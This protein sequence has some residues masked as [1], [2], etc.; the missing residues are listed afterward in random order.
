MSTAIKNALLRAASNE[1]SNQPVVKRLLQELIDNIAGIGPGGGGTA[2]LS[3]CLFVDPAAPG[4]G[5]RSIASLELPN[6][7]PGTL[8]GIQAALNAALPGDAVVLSP[9]T[10]DFGSGGL[11]WPDPAGKGPVSLLGLDAKATIL[12]NDGTVPVILFD[13]PTVDAVLEELSF[14]TFDAPVTPGTPILSIVGRVDGGAV[15]I[16]RCE[17]FPFKTAIVASNTVPASAVNVV[18]SLC[19]FRGDMIFGDCASV[20]F[21]Y[22]EAGKGGVDIQTPAAV[23]TQL[24]LRYSSVGALAVGSALA[25]A[26]ATISQDKHSTIDGSNIW[27]LAAS[28]LIDCR[29]LFD[30]DL[31]LSLPDAVGGWRFNSATFL[32]GFTAVGTGPARA[33][34]EATGCTWRT[35]NTITAND[36]V[37]LD[38]RGASYPGTGLFASPGM[39]GG[40]ID[41]DSYEAN[42]TSLTDVAGAYDIPF[43]LDAGGGCANVPFPA[44]VSFPSGYVV[45]FAPRDAAT[46]LVSLFV[47]G[48]DNT[49]VTLTGVPASSPGVSLLVSRIR[50]PSCAA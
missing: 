26:V 35:G 31:S 38:I 47:S 14:L 11:V 39:D 44:G 30:G 22:C 16:T 7:F 5:T 4:P 40:T 21:H 10:Y 9:G 8:A 42:V 24:I 27:F 20:E 36:F 33:Y 2:G 29:G 19:T 25:P 32:A 43:D 48:G 49:K 12:T 34:V 15:H 41:R 17:I 23:P 28:S 6:R 1:L 3:T 50:S 18:S 46:V 45:S 13:Q 37:D